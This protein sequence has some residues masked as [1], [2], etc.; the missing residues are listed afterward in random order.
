M[1]AY[2][3]CI[4]VSAISVLQMYDNKKYPPR[5]KQRRGMKPR[6]DG[7]KQMSMLII[8]IVL[9]LW[10]ECVI[11]GLSSLDEP[12]NNTVLIPF[13]ISTDIP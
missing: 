1:P 8:C 7:M 5:K 3:L 12:L 6:L 4:S 2:S 11:H 9:C 10:L 13:I